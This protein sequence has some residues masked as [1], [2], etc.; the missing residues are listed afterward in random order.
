[1]P[2]LKGRDPQKESLSNAI[3]RLRAA[4]KHEQ[5]SDVE[6]AIAN[7]K[8]FLDPEPYQKVL[9][10]ALSIACDKSFR[11]AVE[12]VLSKK[13]D[14][15]A[16][17]TNG[18]PPLR[19]AVEKC[20]KTGCASESIVELLLN[21]GAQ[22]EVF[23]QDKTTPLMLARSTTVIRLLLK[24]GANVNA[25]DNE[26]RSVLMYAQHEDII[27]CLLEHQAKLEARD[28]HGNTA[29]SHYLKRDKDARLAQF[30]IDRNA[31]V[32]AADSVGR[33]VLM[34]AIWKNHADVVK[35]LLFK[36]SVDLS[37]VDSRCRNVWHHFAMDTDRRM[38]GEGDQ[39]AVLF[40]L[41]L[42]ATQ[43]ASAATSDIMKARDVRDRTCLHWAAASGNLWIARALLERGLIEVD[44]L[45]HRNKTPLHLAIRFAGTLDLALLSNSQPS[46]AQNDGAQPEPKPTAHQSNGK[47]APPR[48][49][50]RKQG[51]FETQE[52]SSQSRPVGLVKDI[53]ALLLQ[54]GADVNAESDGGWTPLHTAC[55]EQATPLVVD[56]LLKSG[57]RPNRRTLSGKTP[58]HLSCENGLIELVKYFLER[59]DVIFDTKDNFGN[60]PLLASANSQHLEIVQLLAPWTDRRRN[61][62]SEAAK[63]AAQSFNATIVD[64]GM[65][66]KQLKRRNIRRKTTIYDLLYS[67]PAIDEQA[68]RS[69]S[70]VCSNSSN[71]KTDFRWIHLPVNNVQWCQELITKRFIE[72]GAVD[73]EG[74]KLLER[75]FLYQHRGQKVHS[76]YMRPMCRTVPRSKH[77]AR[78]E[79]EEE[80]SPV[81]NIIVTQH[82][83]PG[84]LP[85]RQS[86]TDVPS[87][88]LSTD[89]S[90]PNL[91]APR[92]ASTMNSVSNYEIGELERTAEG[93]ARS[94]S[95]SRPRE[96]PESVKKARA[97]SAKYPETN[98]FL[99]APYLHFETDLRR[100]EMQRA[101]QAMQT[102]QLTAGGGKQVVCTIV[103]DNEVLEN[104]PEFALYQAH[105]HSELHIRRTLDQSFYRTIDTDARDTDQVIYRYEQELSE[106]KQQEDPRDDVKVLMVDQLWMW[107][108]G[109]D[110]VVTSFPQR[111]RQPPKDPLNVL[112]G[113]MEEIN[114]TTAE[115]VDNVY[116]L[117]ILI[118]GRCFG[119]FDQSDVRSDGSRFLDMFESSIG[120]AMDD[121]THFFA[122]FDLA[123]RQI[124]GFLSS[125]L[126]TQSQQMRD[127]NDLRNLP[128]HK[129][130]G[131][132]RH[133]HRSALL[134]NKHP[135]AM[136]TLLD[137]AAEIE[138]LSDVKD[139]RDELDMLRLV[140]EQQTQVIPGVHEAVDTILGHEKGSEGKRNKVLNR[141]GYH[142]RAIDR[143]VKEI[144]R[145]DK[146]A[147]RIYVSIRDLLDLKQKH[148]NAVEASYARIQASE[149]ARQG[150]I[151]MVFTIVTVIF[152]PLSFIAAFLDLEIA[153]YPHSQGSQQ[154]TL[155][156]ALKYTLGIGGGIAA[157][158]VI[159]ALSANRMQREVRRLWA[160]MTGH[161]DPPDDTQQRSQKQE[162]PGPP[163]AT[164]KTVDREIT[165]D[166]RSRARRSLRPASLRGA[167][168]AGVEK[169]LV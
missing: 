61:R 60:T 129:P 29:L 34:Y 105:L 163:A 95:H 44:V 83:S 78:E 169:S 54:Y 114:S 15:N 155:G 42:G 27:S 142:E 133:S 121:E 165:S 109:D 3:S 154:L 46:A 76:S 90:P 50:V 167:E 134:K 8:E 145:M 141:L 68:A 102:A 10:I 84:S 151:L 120:K 22:A 72:E 75:A 18:H 40:D 124:S 88:R 7:A 150:Q 55:V 128:A 116:D 147:E 24:H 97:R 66:R 86:N 96:A 51:S 74:F 157:I 35:R 67:E 65:Y 99:F 101:L 59:K 126:A 77:V 82:A 33:T 100:R 14:P 30:L 53:V 160:H 87:W 16:R 162:R 20:G 153:E 106:S 43:K 13:A 152:L 81:K 41:L 2:S 158:C 28:H 122:E 5:L 110:L 89:F 26:G 161:F 48:G 57:A 135:R 58:F 79:P 111:W 137:I 62:L 37:Q 11:A 146:Q 31:D 113:I 149:T 131:S 45:E 80:K 19:R 130:A 39:T 119:T 98:V 21:H 164:G 38:H 168:A 47:L 117:A 132:Q 91:R 140:F 159:L 25:T 93:T 71:D 6:T 138:L 166:I 69:L 12:F 123:S 73:I 108:L 49:K 32:N 85:V 112:E 103:A 52:Q 107:I 94:R 36:E 127:S 148:A 92:R 23:G 118:A 115:S 143:S 9:D 136:Q 144:E 63:K 139:I 56:Q 156:Y 17:A 70:T 1:M 104:S 64:F 4:F 125:T